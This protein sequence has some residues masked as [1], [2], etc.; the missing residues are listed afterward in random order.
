[1]ITRLDATRLVF[2][3]LL[4]W[5]LALSSLGNISDIPDSLCFEY[6]DKLSLSIRLYEASPLLKL[7]FR[8]NLL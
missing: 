4:G 1:M 2:A 7:Q 6:R 3:D 8:R 5:K